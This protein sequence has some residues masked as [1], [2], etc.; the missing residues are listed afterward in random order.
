MLKE[1]IKII[2]FSQGFLILDETQEIILDAYD[3]GWDVC[4]DLTVYCSCTIEEYYSV[5]EETEEEYLDIFAEWANE[6]LEDFVD[7]RKEIK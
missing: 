1:N 2:P 4:D 7:I 6:N 3:G 5:G